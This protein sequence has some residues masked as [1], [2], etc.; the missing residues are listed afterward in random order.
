MVNAYLMTYWSCSECGGEYETQEEAE[1][2]CQP[3][4]L[5]EIEPEE[6]K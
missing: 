3:N 1:N 2:C 4:E 5:E 6:E